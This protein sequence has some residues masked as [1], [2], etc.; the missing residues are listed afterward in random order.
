MAV[1]GGAEYP[2]WYA[3]YDGVPDFSDFKGFNGWAHPAIKVPPP[4]PASTHTRRCT[5]VASYRVSP[6]RVGHTLLFVD[7]RRLPMPR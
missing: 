5:L 1:A 4:P 3:H 2:L 6:R 7:E